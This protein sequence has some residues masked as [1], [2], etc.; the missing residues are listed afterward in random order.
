MCAG[1]AGKHAVYDRY[2]AFLL[3]IACHAAVWHTR[4]AFWER[5]GHLCCV[6]CLGNAIDYSRADSLAMINGYIAHTAY[7]ITHQCWQSDHTWMC[8]VCECVVWRSGTAVCSLMPAPRHV[9]IADLYAPRAKI[10][11][12]S[13]T[14][15]S[16][17]AG[18]GA[19]ACRCAL[20][21][22]TEKI[23]KVT[24]HGSLW[25]LTDLWW[26]VTGEWH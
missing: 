22:G 11:E 8:C 23:N 16:N 2:A 6:H 20:G 25:H 7:S 21:K 10:S 19:I 4:G 12:A 13:P 24:W 18:A 5:R 1:Q 26:E 3:L 9:S 17:Q 15:N 14:Y